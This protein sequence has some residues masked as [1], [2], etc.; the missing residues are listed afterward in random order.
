MGG[1][2]TKYKTCELYKGKFLPA[3][4]DGTYGERVFFFFFEVSSFRASPLSL[5][6][7]MLKNN[8]NDN[9]KNKT[10]GFI[11]GLDCSGSSGPAPE[12][13]PKPM[14]VVTPVTMGP[15]MFKN[16]QGDLL[17]RIAD[18]D[19]GEC[20]DKCKKEVACAGIN[21]CKGPVQSSAEQVC[22]GNVRVGVCDLKKFDGEAK[23]WED[24]TAQEGDGWMSSVKKKAEVSTSPPEKQPR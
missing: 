3:N 14:P 8:N 13:V 11:L 22:S 12:I 19:F 9:E 15:S 23:Y 7:S 18:S 16:L 24:T 21:F 6:L 5:S 10:G 2:D 1:P 4:D 20:M 17:K